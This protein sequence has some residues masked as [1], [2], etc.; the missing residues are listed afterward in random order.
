MTQEQKNEAIKAIEN[1][2][3]T[4]RNEEKV[5]AFKI[6]QGFQVAETLLNIPNAAF[7]AYKAL[8][9]IPYVGPALGAAAAI[10]TTTLGFTKIAMIKKQKPPAFE[11]GSFEVPETVTRV[12]VIPV[13]QLGSSK[14]AS[15]WARV[16]PATKGW[17]TAFSYFFSEIVTD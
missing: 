3:N 11:K 9:G 1:N 12:L 8:A 5:K 6:Q 2:Y 13:C 10:A 17:I 4:K 16:N 15:A 14:R 7:A